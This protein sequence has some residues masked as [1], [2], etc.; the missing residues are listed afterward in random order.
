MFFIIYL[1]LIKGGNNL[2]LRR[3][4]LVCF[5]FRAMWADSDPIRSRINQ[6]LSIQR[7]LNNVNAAA[8]P[9]TSVQL[10]PV[11]RL[12]LQLTLFVFFFFFA[13]SRASST[14]RP[15]FSSLH[16]PR[17][18]KSS[19][20]LSIKVFII[21]LSIILRKKNFSVEEVFNLFAPSKAF[22]EEFWN[23]LVI[24]D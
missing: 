11:K 9:K 1:F 14:L 8:S 6:C 20:F 5:F 19:P 13:Q 10:N 24:V 21:I 3:Y 22:A 16:Y 7:N 12:G 18:E 15:S 23:T 2:A 4:I 17:L